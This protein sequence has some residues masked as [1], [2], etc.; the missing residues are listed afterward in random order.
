MY[1]SARDWGLSPSEFWAMT[2][3]EWFLEFEYRRASTPGDY[4]G[5]LTGAAIEEIKAFMEEG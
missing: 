1:L 2:F 3:G 4:A 5:K